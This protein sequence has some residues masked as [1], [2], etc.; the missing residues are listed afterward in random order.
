MLRLGR[1]Y[2]FDGI[3]KESLE[4]IREVIPT[5]LD[6]FN[7]LPK[8]FSGSNY[9]RAYVLLEIL[10]EIGNQTLLPTV[11]FYCSAYM[12]VVCLLFCLR[13][14][15]GVDLQDS[16]GYSIIVEEALSGIYPLYLRQ[17]LR[18]VKNSPLHLRKS[19]SGGHCQHPQPD[20]G[21]NLRTKYAKC[22]I[23]VLHQNERS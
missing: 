11:Y 8:A 3:F 15:C 1:K 16:Q 12:D 9:R 14:V 6:Q 20:L 19:R 17:S 18:D 22:H 13:G 23:Y 2:Q 7:G 21:S 5:T 4:R 10:L